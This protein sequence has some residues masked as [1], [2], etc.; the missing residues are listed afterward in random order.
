VSA[1]SS[2]ADI[3]P[4]LIQ[5][6]RERLARAAQTPGSGGDASGLLALAERVRAKLPPMASSASDAVAAWPS[7]RIGLGEFVSQALRARGVTVEWLPVMSIGDAGERRDRVVLGKPGQAGHF[8]YGPYGRL[9]PG[10]YLLKIRISAEPSTTS[11]AQ[12]GPVATIEAM[13]GKSELMRHDLR[14]DD[15]ASPE[16]HLSFRVAG[17]PHQAPVE[18]RIWTSGAVALTVSSIIVER[19]G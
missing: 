16:H 3:D 12:R 17:T 10:T 7:A 14:L 4:V 5:R 8:I 1:D 2:A 6:A 9:E 19:I 13:S 11:R 18:V 15:C